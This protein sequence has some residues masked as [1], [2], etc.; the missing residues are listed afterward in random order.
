MVEV[1]EMDHTVHGRRGSPAAEREEG[2]TAGEI[3]AA[4]G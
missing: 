4:N 3:G 1:D 2:T